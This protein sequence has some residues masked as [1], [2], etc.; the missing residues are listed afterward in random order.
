MWPNL[1]HNTAAILAQAGPSAPAAANPSQVAYL[2]WGLICIAVA[3]ILFLIEVFVPSAGVIALTASG[4]LV[5]GVVLLFL[6]NTALGMIAAIA[7]L[8]AMPFFF[9]FV[10]RLWPNTPIFR[11]LL[12]KNAPGQPV[13]SSEAPP[14]AASPLLGRTG[15]AVSD[16]RPVGTCVIEGKRLECL[17]EGGMI[18]AG[19]RVRV[20]SVNGMEVKVRAEE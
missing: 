15:K 19:A 13:K 16:L 20:T 9:V 3:A 1:L 7:A 6:N 11:L 10:L 2:T 5:T 17:A 14:M 8:V 12:L 18:A 4:A